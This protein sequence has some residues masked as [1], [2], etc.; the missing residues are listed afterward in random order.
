MKKGEDESIFAFLFGAMLLMEHVDYKTVI[1]P[2]ATNLNLK[3]IGGNS[4]KSRLNI[5][6]FIIIIFITLVKLSAS[7]R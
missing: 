5:F 6:Y 7:N 3:P 4:R 2:N 1:C